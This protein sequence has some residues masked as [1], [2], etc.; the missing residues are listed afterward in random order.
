MKR[1]YNPHYLP[2]WIRKPRFYCKA[3]CIPITCFQLVR[4]LIVPTTGDFLLLLFLV[5]LSFMFYHDV[6]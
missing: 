3:I 4:V 1:R 5:A 2:E 6:I